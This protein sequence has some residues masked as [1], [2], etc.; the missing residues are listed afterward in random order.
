MMFEKMDA[1]FLL[2]ER[3]MECWQVVDDIK[4]TWEEFSDGKEEM[5][6]D[7][8]CNILLGMQTLYDRKFARLFSSY[9][10]M[11]EE[12]RQED[13]TG[14]E[15]DQTF[16]DRLSDEI[17]TNHVHLKSTDMKEANFNGL[18]ESTKKIIAK[19]PIYITKV[20]EAKPAPETNQEW[21]PDRMDIIGQNG[22]DGLHYDQGQIDPIGNL[23][24]EEGEE[25]F[26][27]LKDEPPPPRPL[28]KRD[29]RK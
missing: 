17:P 14:Q 29:W 20:T 4:I 23:I 11:L 12:M 7:E 21:S 2:E 18:T 10:K 16:I 1:R 27:L 19:T 5:D 28:W 15:D 26:W 24:P 6:T 8:L 9:E 22:N 13:E 25:E 3:I